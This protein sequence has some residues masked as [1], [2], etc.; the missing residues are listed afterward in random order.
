MRNQTTIILKKEI[1]GLG[2]L[3][4]MGKKFVVLKKEH[5]EELLILLKSVIEGERLLKKK[6]T[7]SFSEFLKAISKK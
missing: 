3:E 4:I 7:R 1:K 6:K 2:N 5:L